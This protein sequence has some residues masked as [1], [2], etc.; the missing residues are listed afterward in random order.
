MKQIMLFLLVPLLIT[1]A[2]SR[3]EP[4]APGKAAMT[5]GAG[6]KAKVTLD[7]FSGRENPSWQLSEEQINKLLSTLDALP[8]SERVRFFDGLGYRGFLVSLTE[9]ASSKEAGSIKAYKGAVLYSAGGVEK[10]FTDKER[11]VENLLLESGG[12]QLGADIRDIVKREIEP[13]KP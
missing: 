11:R 1:C 2:V 10:F 6:K 7:I 9:A 3:S 12:S 8:T 13:P 4:A 5:N